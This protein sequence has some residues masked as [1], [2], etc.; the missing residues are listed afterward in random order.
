[1]KEDRKVVS[2]AIR[3]LLGV[4]RD[5]IPNGRDYPTAEYTEARISWLDKMDR[6]RAVYLE[7]VD[8]QVRSDRGCSNLASPNGANLK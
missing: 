4:M 3:E 5:R 7:L 6:I 2:A 8:E 1:M